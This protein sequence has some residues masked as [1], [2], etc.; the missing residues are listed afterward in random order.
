MVKYNNEIEWFTQ[1]I[2]NK[3]FVNLNI[4]EKQK[5][6]IL[7]VLKFL[8]EDNEKTLRKQATIKMLPKIIESNV[9][10]CYVQRF[11]RAK[12]IGSKVTL[13]KQCILYGRERG[14]EYWNVYREKQRLSNTFEYKKQKY[15][16]SE[17][18]FD[19]YNKSRSVTLFNCIKRH[20]EDKGT[21]IYKS[22]V[23]KQKYS[24]SSLEYFIEKYGEEKGN[25]EWDRICKE[26]SL[27][28]DNFVRKYGEIDGKIRYEIVLS[29]LCRRIPYSKISQEL[30][31]EIY[32]NLPDDIK[33]TCYFF[34]LNSEYHKVL[35]NKCCFIDFFIEQLN[36]SIEFYGD[37]FHANPIK[38]KDD[39]IVPIHNIK[40]KD[41]WKKDSERISS[42]EKLHNIKTE[43]IW[44]HDYLNDKQSSVK[45]LVELIKNEYYN[46]K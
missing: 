31:W 36:L 32:D 25:S 44:E 15:G 42:L 7:K 34:E 33:S 41:I 35:D 10:S 37:L 20:G 12:K 18:Q 13:L 1:L 21:E 39:D 23:K 46:N 4:T 16:W 43:I 45:K 3:N 11:L 17:E 22:Y 9:N 14:L 38:Y 26:K 24:G 30:F 28:L 40:A 2:K 19:E 29:K 6:Q 27:T 5:I 8:L